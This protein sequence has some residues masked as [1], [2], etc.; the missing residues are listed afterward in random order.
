MVYLLAARKQ[1]LENEL[2]ERVQAF[3]EANNETP[4]S[5]S[6]SMEMSDSDPNEDLSTIRIHI[7]DALSNSSLNDDFTLSKT[8]DVT[9][10]SPAWLTR[11]IVR[12]KKPP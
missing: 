6:I 4:E 1:E 12:R 7:K 8:S 2:R 11:F 9:T 3:F 10:L 5:V